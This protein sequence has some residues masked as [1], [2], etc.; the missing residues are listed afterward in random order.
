MQTVLSVDKDV[1]HWWESK[2][3][4]G[5][6]GSQRGQKLFS[7]WEPKC[8]MLWDKNHSVHFESYQRDTRMPEA[9]VSRCPHT[10]GELTS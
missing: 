4:D 10:V 3:K 8:F 2:G 5:W 6:L 7:I 1:V 9:F